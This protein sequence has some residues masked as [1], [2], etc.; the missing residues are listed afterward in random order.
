MAWGSSFFAS[1]VSGGK[2]T[3]RNAVPPR[4]G[5]M[6]MSI[7][8]RSLPPPRS[9]GVSSVTHSRRDTVCACGRTFLCGLAPSSSTTALSFL[10]TV[11]TTRRTS[12]LKAMFPPSSARECSSYSVIAGNDTASATPARQTL[13]RLR[14]AQ[15][16][17]ESGGL[18][19]AVAPGVVGAAL[20][21]HV[22]GAQQHLALVH[23]RV[24]L[25]GEHDRVVDRGGLVEAGMARRAA[26]EGGAV[27]GAVVGA[28]ALRLE[29]GE[30]LPVRG[31]FDDAEDRAVLRRREPKRMIGDLG[32]AAVVGRGR[33]RLPELG[34]DRAAGA[35]AVDVRRRAAHH[36]HG[37]AGAVP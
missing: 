13:H 3:M 20:N 6:P 22:A 5:M 24:N 37:P 36:E 8:A 11:V 2:S 25:A 21:E 15:H 34:D 17:G 16:E 32:P 27:A 7:A 18:V 12:A 26:I 9:A 23:Q 29:R 35:A 30:A 10:S 31:I 28:C 33:A 19:A 1:A 4:G 14:V